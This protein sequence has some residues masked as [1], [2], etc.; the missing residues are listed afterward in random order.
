MKKREGILLFIASCLIS[1]AGKDGDSLVCLSPS[2]EAVTSCLLS[3]PS[4]YED[5]AQEQGTLTELSYLT[6]HYA[7][8]AKESL[9]KQCVVYT[10]YAYDAT[11]PYD[12][13]YLMHGHMSDIHTL[14]GWGK[15]KNVIDHAIADKKVRPLLLVMPTFAPHNEKETLGYNQAIGEL[16]HFPEE[17]VND[18]MPFIETKYLTYA[19]KDTAQFASSRAHRGFGGFSLGAVTTWCMFASQMQTIQTFVPLA[20]D[21]WV[22]GNEPN[23]DPD[24]ASKT[25]LYLKN[26]CK[27]GLDFSFHQFAGEKESF[28][29]SIDGMM[30]A[31]R[32]I[33]DPFTS[34]NAR[35]SILPEG[36]H[37]FPEARQYFYN[38]MREYYPYE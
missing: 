12:I 20:A 33:G 11:K 19:Q 32:A 29:P 8:V 28:F 16:K 4:A 1:C 21:C 37:D 18:L 36:T 5:E 26:Q 17:F 24:T 7:A 25:A 13:F 30:K 9:T 34:E 38:A 22:Y 23:A 14:M 6:Y 15:F 31:I 27:T 10:P 2:N 35:Y 3:L